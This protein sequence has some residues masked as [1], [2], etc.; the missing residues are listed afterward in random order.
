M[1]MKTLAYR[2]MRD[3]LNIGTMSGGTRADPGA[4]TWSYPSTAIKCQVLLGKSDEVPDGT[5]TTLTSGDIWVP[6]DTAITA[7]Q[8][9]KV[10]KRHRETL[11]TPEIYTVI[12]APDDRKHALV[13]H[14]QRVTGNQAP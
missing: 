11:A 7:K 6:V 13:L 3:T 5:Q 9:V 4:G 2:N 8:R 14:V 10:T 1:R 12:G